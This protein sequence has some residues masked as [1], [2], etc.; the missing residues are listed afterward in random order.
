MTDSTSSRH[1]P[2]LLPLTTF[3]ISLSLFLS[4]SYVFCVLSYMLF[5]GL[6]IRHS[7]VL[8][9]PGFS[10]LSWQSFL[11]G[12]AEAF[13]WGWYV[14]LVFVPIFNFSSG[15]RASMQQP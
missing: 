12:L 9:L 3:G 10:F 11:L 14:A 13:G 4:L 8:I 7:L 15:R 1:Q 2:V 6:P 5:P